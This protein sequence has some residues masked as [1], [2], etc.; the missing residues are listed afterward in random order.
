M[1]G[2]LINPDNLDFSEIDLTAPNLV[3]KELLSQLPELTH[4]I[5]RGEITEYNGHVISYTR[6]RRSLAEVFG[7]MTTE[8]HVDIQESLGKQ[9]EECNKYECYLY[10]D[11]YDRYRYRLFFMQYGI[12]HYPVQLTVEESIAHSIQSTNSGYIFNCRNREEVEELIL[13]IFAC[14]KVSGV[15][16]ELIRIYQAKKLDESENGMSENSEGE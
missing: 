4:G 11:R 13:R 6:T 10:T 8:E 9:G 12:G 3:V 7:D 16:Q 14:Q 2:N 5:I 15:M 1:S